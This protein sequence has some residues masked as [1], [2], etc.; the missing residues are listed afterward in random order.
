M[1]RLLSIAL[2]LFIAS[3]S[4]WGQRIKVSCIGDSITY[5]LT[6]QDP[7]TQSYPAQL[8]RLLGES[9]QVGRF[10]KSGATLL[11][12]GHR[13]YMDQEEFRQ[14]LDFA[15]DIIVIHLGVNDT[16]PRNW[17]NYSDEFIPDYLALID[18]LR[19][20]NPRARVL[21]ARITPIGRQHY[22]F[23]SGTLCWH[24]QIQQAIETVARVSGARLIDFYTPLLSRPDLLPDAVHPNEEGSGILAKTVFSA[25]TGDYG[26]LAMSPLY[27]DNMV[28]P[29]DRSFPIT[30]TANAGDRVSVKLGCRHYTTVAGSDGRW[31]VNAGPFKACESTTLTVSAGGSKL[32]F[33]NVA[34]G[35]IWLCSG[36]SNMEF[37]LRQSESAPDALYSADS[38]LRLFDSKCNWRT[39][40]V[41]WSASR[42]SAAG[43]YFGRMLRDSLKV[44]VGLICNAVGGSPQEA[45]IDRNTLE[46]SY[47]MIL[48]DWLHSDFIM[49]WV[50]ERAWCNMGGEP[51]RHPYEPSYLFEAAILPMQHFPIS[52][53]IW[54]QGESNA[55]NVEVFEELFPLFVDSW[56]RYFGENLPIYY[57]QLSSLE[58]PSWARFRDAQRRLAGCRPGL[59]MAVTADLGEQWEVHFRNKRP[60][61]ERLAG[62]ALSG[63]YGRK[64]PAGSPVPQSAEVAA[65][66]VTVR[67]DRSLQ[68][69]GGAADGF[70]ILDAADGLY[71]AVPAS[72]DGASVLLDAASVR[73]PAAVRYAWRPYTTANLT[74]TAGLP[75][76]TFRLEL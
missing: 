36:Q 12:H 52:G 17:P 76:S 32:R 18:S 47:P 71:H 3:S 8:Q 60:V 49:P 6:L 44:P 43:Y 74:D 15:G 29:R 34:I 51:G 37:E 46:D 11:R 68:A 4:V 24:R 26:G 28:L 65:G 73:Q 69:P 64:I 35:E 5:G 13:P 40:N 33:R 70:E 53:V 41:V 45:W 67:F 2:C 27:T 50:R 31:S 25:I 72:V 62:L 63:T 59:G 23:L 42:F 56:R 19:S 66:K 9:Y 14:A 10:G 39:D 22:R 38:A 75:V 16:D 21:I 57:A 30:G 20:R 58:R 7:A 1:K 55:H 54:Y 61:G 48:L